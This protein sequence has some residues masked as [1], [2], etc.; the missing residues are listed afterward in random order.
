MDCSPNA[1]ASADKMTPDAP[2][3]PSTT[4]PPATTPTPT[5]TASPRRRSDAPPT[6]SGRGYRALFHPPPRLARGLRG[7]Q[8]LVSQPHRLRV[9]AMGRT[10]VRC[11]WASAPC[12]W[13]HRRPSRLLGRGEA[14][15]LPRV[16]GTVGP[17]TRTASHLWPAGPGKTPSQLVES[18]WNA[19]CQRLR[20]HRRARHLRAEGQLA[21]LAPEDVTA[22]P[23]GE[24]IIG[25]PV[26]ASQRR[27]HRRPAHH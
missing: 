6:T 24:P 1:M 4:S 9:A 23:A 13:P 20:P 17:R 25:R 14:G 3:R 18:R 12:A 19:S 27:A 2:A 5:A 15:F 16:H 11:R 21:D 7:G 22:E 8:E 10:L 26:R